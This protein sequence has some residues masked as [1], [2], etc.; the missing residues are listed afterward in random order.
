MDRPRTIVV[1]IVGVDGSGKSAT[2]QGILERLAP[3]IAV[4]GIG[5]RVL[6]GDPG[7]VLHE[8]RDLG[9]G[10]GI[11]LVAGMARRRSASR[12]YRWLKLV[13]LIGRARMRD[14]FVRAGHARV[15][16]TD[17]DPLLNSA[18]WS[19]AR[20]HAADLADDDALL[21]RVMDVLAG[22]AHI[23]VRELEAYLRHAPELVVVERL[24]LC[25]FAPPDVAILL[26]LPG[27]VAMT[28]IRGRGRP[29]QAHEDAAFLDALGRQYARAG[30]LLAAHRGVE[31]VRLPVSTLDAASVVDA[32]HR[33]VADRLAR[34]AAEAAAARDPA[35]VRS[36]I[37]VIAT[38]ISG[39]LRDQRDV[40]RIEPVVRSLTGRRVV[41]HV[42]DDHAA[43]RRAAH[44]AVRAGARTIVSAGGAGTFNAVL[45]GCHLDGAIPADLSLA[46]LRKGSADLIGKALRVPS[47]LEAGAAAIV[48][49]LDAE[50]RVTADVLSVS[51]TDPDG[52]RVSRHLVGFGGTGVFGD[53]PRYTEARFVKLYKGILGSLFGDYGPFF[54]G[55][56]LASGR[57]LVERTRGRIVPATLVLDGVPTPCRAWT[58]VI[59]VN[60]DLGPDFPLGRGLAFD[61]GRFRVVA[62]PDRGLRGALVQLR[63]CRSGRILDDPA[64]AG[65]LVREVRELRIEPAGRRPFMVNVDGLRMPARGSVRLAVSGRVR[66]VPAGPEPP[67]AAPGTSGGRA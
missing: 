55:L 41:V 45:E 3:E 11:G 18:A 42:A 17:G 8:R 24:R 31:L 20:F 10:R 50:A 37:H 57:W 7:A 46:F 59:V 13:D 25:R 26:E 4:T 44:D 27:D 47:G 19:A 5:D 14:A 65:A 35:V 54:T 61:A 1:A 52:R 32:A 58:A 33:A 16:V 21:L 6:T 15:I 48:R 40:G 28:R 62:L 23:P 43:A 63:A 56:A 51:A 9:L 39:S 36:A 2:W 38:T 60:G 64:A 22:D 30:G 67:A 12:T 29:P 53:V 34:D 66:L 49:G